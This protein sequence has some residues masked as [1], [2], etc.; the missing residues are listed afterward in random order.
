MLPAS[1]RDLLANH[2]LAVKK[3]HEADLA[4][5]AGYVVSGFFLPVRVVSRLFR[6][7]FLAE[8][9]HAFRAGSLEFHGRLAPLASPAAFDS[10]LERARETEWVVYAK[11]PFERPENVLEYLAC[12]T[13]RIAI[14]NH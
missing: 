3:L 8:L 11:P 14:S 13:H 12:Y 5:G 1:I 10:D 9:K 6:G 7:K 2:L 4:A